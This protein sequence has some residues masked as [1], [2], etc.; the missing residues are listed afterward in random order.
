MNTSK[1]VVMYD[2]EMSTGPGAIQFPETI[3]LRMAGWAQGRAGTSREEW[4]GPLGTAPYGDD[5]AD[6]AMI[7][8]GIDY[9]NANCWKGK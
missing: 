5:P 8:K 9:Y 4:G 6:Q 1:V 2:L 7:Q 3:L